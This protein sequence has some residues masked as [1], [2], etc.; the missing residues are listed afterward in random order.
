VSKDAGFGTVVLDDRLGVE[1][2]KTE[3]VFDSETLH[4]SGHEPGTK[5][6]TGACA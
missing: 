1:E 6:V 5:G 4:Q 2:R 3:G